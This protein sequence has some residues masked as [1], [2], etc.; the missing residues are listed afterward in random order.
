MSARRLLVTTLSLQ[1][2]WCL[3]LCMQQRGEESENIEMVLLSGVLRAEVITDYRSLT[4]H[5]L[6]DTGLRQ[7]RHVNA[8]KFCQVFLALLRR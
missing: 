3:N 2:L 8:Q 6:P 5:R 7:C 1:K 4:R